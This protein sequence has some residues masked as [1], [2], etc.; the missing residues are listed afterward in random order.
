MRLADFTFTQLC[1]TNFNAYLSAKYL[2]FIYTDPFLHKCMKFVICSIVN[3]S[4]ILGM[5]KHYSFMV[6]S[7]FSCKAFFAFNAVTTFLPVFASSSFIA[8]LA[9]LPPCFATFLLSSKPFGPTACRNIF[10]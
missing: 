2:R 9:T 6:L 3:N 7:F 4:I 1:K 8:T 10:G 5:Y